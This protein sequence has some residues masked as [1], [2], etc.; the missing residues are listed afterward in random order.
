MD[1]HS[2]STAAFGDLH[3]YFW[4]S[5]PSITRPSSFVECSS[6]RNTS[7]TDQSHRFPIS[8]TSWRH[9]S[10]INVNF[11]YRFGLQ[12]LGY[13]FSISFMVYA[14]LHNKQLTNRSGSMTPRPLPLDPGPPT[15]VPPQPMYIRTPLQVHRPLVRVPLHLPSRKRPM[16]LANRLTMN[17]PLTYRR[18]TPAMDM[19]PDNT[20]LLAQ[21]VQSLRATLRNPPTQDSCAVCE[22]A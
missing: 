22:V 8:K 14:I 16:T 6:P 12:H 13:Q 20:A 19:P 21:Q 10:Y 18:T 5:N 11:E 4:F 9:V 2:R 1:R 17:E 7:F 3:W 15:A